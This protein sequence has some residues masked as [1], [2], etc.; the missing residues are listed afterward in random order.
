LRDF[1]PF[2]H[3]TCHKHIV[4]RVR[5]ITLFDIKRLIYS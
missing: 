1:L 2:A 5:I 3:F 4:A